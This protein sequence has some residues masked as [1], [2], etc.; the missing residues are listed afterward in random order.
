MSDHD[1]KDML[2][3]ASEAENIG[4][5]DEENG[6]EIFDKMIEDLV[7]VESRP[8]DEMPVIPLRGISIFPTMVIH[9]DVGR[10]EVRQRAGIRHA[11]GSDGL[12]G[13]AEKFRDRPA[14]AGRFLS[15]RYGG[16]H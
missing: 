5:M 14:D 7:H 6:D 13:H 11:V 16:T 1:P 10:R 8:S 4:E 3:T 2:K 12:S 15:V 9:F